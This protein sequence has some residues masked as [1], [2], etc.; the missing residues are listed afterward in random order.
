MPERR[1]R[2]LTIAAHPVPYAVPVFRLMAQHPRLDFQVA[3]CSLGGAEV[4]HDPEFGR[5]VQWDIPLL[6]GYRWTHVSNRG[7]GS[8]SFFGVYNPALWKLI[9]RGGFDAI[10]CHLSYLQASFWLSFFSARHYRTAF[11]FGCDQGSLDSRDGRSWKKKLKQIV[12]PSLFRLA[13]QV[14]VSSSS[15]KQLLSSLRVPI[16]RISLTPLVVSNDW[17]VSQSAF[18]SRDEVRSSWGV[19]KE[20][21]VVLFCSKL[22]PWKRPLDLLRAAAMCKLPELFLVFAGD[23][24]LL[25]QLKI[26][27]AAL[28]IADRVRFL[29]FRNQSELPAIYASAD[30][31]VLPSEYEPFAVVVNEAMCCGCAVIASDRVGSAKDLV[32]PICGEFIFPCG[33]VDALARILSRIANDRPLL[34]RVKHLAVSHMQ[35]WSP[36]RNVSATVDAIRLA[37][38]RRRD[39]NRESKESLVASSGPSESGVRPR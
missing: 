35:T 23:G 39:Q 28:G 10:L 13:D 8:Q 14:V 2:V 9:R 4:A 5:S 6:D 16:E 38:D 15:A 20:G 29:G 33:D 25:E 1:F 18:V 19:S 3:Y 7:S 17:W 37:I 27:A 30:V 22:Q 34:H 26:E 24:P 12:W 11:I 32:A 21:I 31:M 36:E